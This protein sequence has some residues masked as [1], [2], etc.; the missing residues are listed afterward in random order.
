MG[1]SAFAS[2][3]D[4]LFTPRMSP[5]VYE[6]SKAQYHAV[7]RELYHCVASPI[8]GP[9][10]EDFGDIDI[11]VAW[12]SFTSDGIQHAFRTIKETLGAVKVIYEGGKSTSANFA[13]PWPAAVANVER[14]SS[15]GRNPSPMEH[16]AEDKFV[17]VDV[18]ICSSLDQFQ[19]MLF[20]HG[21]GDIWNLLG[22][23]VRPYGLTVDDDAMWLRIPEIEKKNRKQAKVFLSRNPE[24]VLR[25][26]GLPMESYW[27]K[28]FEHVDDMFEYVARCRMFHVAPHESSSSDEFLQSL[29]SNDRRRMSYRPV[30]REWVERFIPQCQ[31]QQRYVHQQ[32]NRDEVTGEA[33]KLFGVENEYASRRHQ[34][35]LEQQRDHIW[36]RVIKA[37]IP[38]ADPSKP[39][40]ILHRSLLV[41]A[42]KKIIL[43][44][45]ESFDV[46]LDASF[47]DDQG[48]FVV[49]NVQ[50][51]IADH[52]ERVGQAAFARHQHS[53]IE[54]CKKTGS[55]IGAADTGEMSSSKVS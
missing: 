27:E 14:S 53:Y 1:G 55:A 12:P 9:G 5:H 31:A 35:I 3:P 22:T 33:I 29:K 46:A 45:D 24:D 54:R 39:T 7:L 26:L 16:G 2:G 47:K 52:G 30:F 41:K 48:L 23:V 6:I 25:F 19:W 8:E 18:K 17:Q 10:K 37:G 34:G 15:D 44:G 36:T 50:R 11:V 43:D 28:P 49:E 32:T 13:V 38:P 21:H 20:K 40:E 4:A 51:F 42:L